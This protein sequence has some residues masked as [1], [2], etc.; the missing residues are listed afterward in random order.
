MT[1]LNAKLKNSGFSIVNSDYGFEEI[2]S[3][4]EEFEEERKKI[5]ELSYYIDSLRYF[6]YI[7]F[8]F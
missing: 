2:V 7:L 6:T 5:T 4:R 1:S 3:E 8:P